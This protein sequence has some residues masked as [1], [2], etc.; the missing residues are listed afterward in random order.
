MK[1]R[2]Q[3]RLN[4]IIISVTQ[5]QN[6]IY[7]KMGGKKILWMTE[8]RSWGE[9]FWLFADWA[10]TKKF[11]TWRRCIGVWCLFDQKKKPHHILLVLVLDYLLI[12]TGKHF[13]YCV[14]YNKKRML[15]IVVVYQPTDS[16]SLRLTK[17]KQTSSVFIYQP[18]CQLAVC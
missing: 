9:H 11:S 12:S 7:H 1:R 16:L 2:S 4:T 10:E 15:Y 3:K 14:G 5:E 6:V 8:S 13:L 18:C 17:R